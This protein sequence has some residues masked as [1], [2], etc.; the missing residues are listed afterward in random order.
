MSRVVIN[1]KANLLI[2]EAFRIVSDIISQAKGENTAYGRF[3]DFNI[4]NKQYT[5]IHKEGIDSHIFTIF[6]VGYEHKK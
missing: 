5:V 6:Y 1:N 3:H 2:T 4:G